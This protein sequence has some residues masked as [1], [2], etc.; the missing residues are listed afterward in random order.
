MRIAT[1][2][3]KNVFWIYAL[4]NG[5][6]IILKIYFKIKNIKITNIKIT[7]L[8]ETLLFTWQALIDY[9][10][11]LANWNDKDLIISN[12]LEIIRSSSIKLARNR[13]SSIETC[14]VLET[15]L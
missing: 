15:F 11:F 5:T 6:C 10:R 8:R 14:D 4:K 12:T 2:S 7:S 3:P 13:L 1:F 9:D